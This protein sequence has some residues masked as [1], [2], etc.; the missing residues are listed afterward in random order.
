MLCFPNIL[1]FTDQGSDAVNELQERDWR[2]LI[3]TIHRG[4]CVLV[5][6]ADVVSD[7][8]DADQ[9]ALTERLAKHLA[10]LMVR[11]YNLK[12]QATPFADAAALP[13]PAEPAL[14]FQPDADTIA[15]I[16]REHGW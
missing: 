5:L 8:A 6:G 10:A 13:P 1:T 7:P 16:K 14:P 4:N 11:A 15:R 12:L 9:T 2:R 3:E